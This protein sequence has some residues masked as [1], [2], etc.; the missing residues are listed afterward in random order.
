MIPKYSSSKPNNSLVILVISKT[1]ITLPD[2]FFIG[3]NIEFSGATYYDLK[4]VV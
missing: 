4:V 1:A 2:L 3:N